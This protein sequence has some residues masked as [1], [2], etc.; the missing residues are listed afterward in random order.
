MLRRAVLAWDAHVRRDAGAL[1]V[2]Q[3]PAMVRGVSLNGH[4][5]GHTAMGGGVGRARRMDWP[6]RMDW[7]RRVGCHAVHA[8]EAQH[9]PEDREEAREST[10]H[11]P[12]RGPEAPLRRPTCVD[13]HGYHA[14]ERPA[15]PARDA[16]AAGH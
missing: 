5:A 6:H 13:L 15:G 16:G 7:A 11:R 2:R 8:Q 1:L 4:H 3:E 12:F 14:T 9:E 10:Q